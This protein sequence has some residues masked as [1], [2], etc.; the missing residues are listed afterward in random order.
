[1]IVITVQ[2]IAFTNRASPSN[3]IAACMQSVCR[4]CGAYTYVHVCCID[5]CACVYATGIDC[6]HLC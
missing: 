6:C 2:S 1:M 5:V 4:V 3:G